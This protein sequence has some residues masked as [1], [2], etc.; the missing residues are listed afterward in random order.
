MMKW[1]HTLIA[2]GALILLTN[3]VALLGAAYNRS[4]EPESL[5]KMTQRELRHN[6]W[7]DKDNSGITLRL[8]W[9][10]ASAKQND[11]D[12]EYYE[13]K[14]GAPTWLD[15]NKMAELGFDVARLAGSYQDGRHY[16]EALPREVLLVLELDGQTYQQALRRAGE[17]AGQ[18]RAKQAANPN[19]ENGKERVKSAEKYYQSELRD[20]SRLFVIDAGVD[21]QKLRASYPDRN[22]YAIVRGLVRPN[23][24]RG[25]DGKIGGNISEL[26]AENIN[27]PLTYRRV[28]DAVAPCEVTVAFGKRLEPWIL[29]ASRSAAAK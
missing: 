7:N 24:V 13:G 23:I 1:S 17:Y 4:D 9:R 29:A 2:G 21:V 10:I 26:H 16:K 19:D 14:W 22:R 8:D 25:N 27:V 5:L 12:I 18:A 11:S 28:F 3:A 20:N 15:K 6:R